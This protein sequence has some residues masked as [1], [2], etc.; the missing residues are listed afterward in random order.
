MVGRAA[1]DAAMKGQSGKMIA[2]ERKYG[3]E[4]VCVPGLVPLGEVANAE[5]RMPDEF[6]DNDNKFVTE[7]FCTYVRPLIGGDLLE[8][9]HLD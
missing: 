1:V 4:Y 6:I 8:Y 7:A 9:V 2:L 5:N 3:K